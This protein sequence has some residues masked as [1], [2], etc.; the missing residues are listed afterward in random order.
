MTVIAVH[1]IDLGKNSCSVA[2]LDEAGRVVLRRKVS[3]DGLV[4]LLARLP[5]CMMATEACCGAHHVERE[6]QAQGH[7]G[8]LMPSKYIRPYVKT[9]KNDDQ[10]AEAIAEAVTRPT[11]LFVSLKEAAQLNV[12]ALH[13]ARAPGRGTDGV[14][15]PD[16]G[17]AAGAR[18]CAAAASPVACGLG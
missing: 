9:Q 17:V 3:R 14:D 13:Q 15:Q 2:G 8:R 18:H 1:G 11:M 7:R 5:G 6:A 16:A 12:R 10:D 4:A